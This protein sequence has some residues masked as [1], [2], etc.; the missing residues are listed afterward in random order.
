VLGAAWRTLFGSDALHYLN[1]FFTALLVGVMGLGAA[2]SN[3]PSPG[4]GRSRLCA[5]NAL[6]SAYAVRLYVEQL[7]TLL[8]VGALLLILR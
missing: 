6:L 2:G 1:V 5:G 3:S 8:A 7:T 4:R